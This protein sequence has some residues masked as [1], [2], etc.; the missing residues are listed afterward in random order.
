M[1][2][3]KSLPLHPVHNTEMINT[4]RGYYAW[5][6]QQCASMQM[7]IKKWD[8]VDRR[9]QFTAVQHEKQLEEEIWGLS[10]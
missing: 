6:H 7:G 9:K 2:L 4:W 5:Y 3:L 10:G 1:I 8:F